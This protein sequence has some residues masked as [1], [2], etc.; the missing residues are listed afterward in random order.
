M[1][2]PIAVNPREETLHPN[3]GD[4]GRSQLIRVLEDDLVATRVSC[5]LGLLRCP[6]RRIR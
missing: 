2:P 4:E 3:G 6:R 1:S 5:A